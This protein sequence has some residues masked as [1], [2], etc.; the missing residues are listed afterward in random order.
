MEVAAPAP[1]YEPRACEPA[2]RRHVWPALGKSRTPGDI[3]YWPR[4]DQIVPFTHWAVYVGRRALAPCGDRWMVDADER[5]G[6]KLPEAVVHLWGAADSSDRDV[7]ANAVVVTNALS[8]VGGSPYDGCVEYDAKHTPM[9]PEQILERALLALSKKMYEERFGGY[10]VLGNNCEHF[11]AWA[12]YGFQKSHQV[13]EGLARGL[14]GGGLILMGPIGAVGGYIAGK[15]AATEVHKQRKIASN[16]HDAILWTTEDE[17]EEVDWVVD[18]LVDNLET[19][20]KHEESERAAHASGRGDRPRGAVDETH[21]GNTSSA[22]HTILAAV[23]WGSRGEGLDVSG[24]VA[25]FGKGVSSGLSQVLAAGPTET[26]AT[27]TRDAGGPH[28]ESAGDNRA[29]EPRSNDVAKHPGDI[30]LGDIF[31][32]HGIGNIFGAVLGGV[33]NVGRAVV[34]EIAEQHSRHQKKLERQRTEC[35]ARGEGEGGGGASGVT[36]EEL[37]DAEAS[38]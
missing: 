32:P 22:E 38:S 29:S 27:E 19:Y 37:P 24:L 28:G 9:R 4:S 18:C 26:G 6:E 31:T 16:A 15:L 11:C 8:E 23:Q 30:A 17:G 2:M 12:R 20:F 21:A 3:L 7:S 14:A 5:T 36:I 25:D 34:G 33:F 10:H 1:K 35:I 13:E